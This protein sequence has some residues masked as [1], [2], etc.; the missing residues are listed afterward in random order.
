VLGVESIVG[1]TMTIRT[2][3]QCVPGGPPPG[4]ARPGTPR[5]NAGSRW[6]IIARRPSEVRD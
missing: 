3:A 4:T 1:M 5:W 6:R 2:I